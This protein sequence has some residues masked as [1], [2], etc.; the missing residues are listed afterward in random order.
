MYNSLTWTIIVEESVSDR[1]QGHLEQPLYRRPLRAFLKGHCEPFLSS[2]RP[3]ET[4]PKATL[5]HLDRAGGI[6]RP[7]WKQL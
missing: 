7:L 4:T 2:G 6:L 1:L 3:S 5:G